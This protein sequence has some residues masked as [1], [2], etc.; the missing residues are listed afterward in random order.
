MKNTEKTALLTD[1]LWR[2][3]LCALLVLASFSLFFLF[4]YFT[5]GEDIWYDEIFSVSYAKKSLSGILELTSL[6]VHPPLYYFYLKGITGLLGVLL[7]SLPF[8]CACKIAS[9][10]PLLLLMILSLTLIRKH[11]GLLTASLFCFFLTAMPQLG[12]YYVEIRMYSLAMLF[13]TGAF[14]SMILILRNFFAG[15]G[16]SNTASRIL[17]L[18][19]G[20]LS[21]YTQYFACIAVIGIYI[22]FFTGIL[23]GRTSSGKGGGFR[24]RFSDPR[25]RKELFFLLISAVLSVLC[26]LPWLPRLLRQIRGVAA[27]YWIQPMSLRSIP[28]TV[29]YIFTP[30]LTGG[31]WDYIPAGL[32][33]GAT[34]I[35]ILLF[36]T[37]LSGGIREKGARAEDAGSGLFARISALIFAFT[38]IFLILFLLAAGYLASFLD[39]P[40]FTYRYLIPVLG[41]FWFGI[42]FIA[43]RIFEGEMERETGKSLS[44]ARLLFPVLLLLTL[45]IFAFG[46]RCTV[47]GFAA[48]ETKKLTEAEKTLSVLSGI[49]ENAV[50]ITNFD[51]VAALSDYYLNTFFEKNAL[52]LLYE[53]T[54]EETAAAMLS[55]PPG[56]LKEGELPGKM[57]LFEK[58]GRPVYFFGSFASRE[59]LL[60]EWTVSGIRSEELSDL[61]LERYWFRICHLAISGE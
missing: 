58:E 32:M 45:G 54:V 26:Y 61:L 27:S 36:L 6:D 52:I 51:H 22:V 53:G 34:L 31:S 29:K 13:V 14:L 41:V 40:V 24:A 12:S 17:F 5:K 20:I 49:E 35:L 46:G 21:A 23:A 55:R 39:H 50:I 7:P 28:G 4:T 18:L 11:F 33:I 59:D 15:T 8:L 37:G 3:L 47:K 2:K 30:V 25:V 56:T 57:L 43:G 44:P 48:E 42:A 60:S 38:G 9:L 1:P 10:L 16:P 19:C